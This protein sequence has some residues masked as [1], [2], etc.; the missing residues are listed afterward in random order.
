MSTV[1]IKS[2]PINGNLLFPIRL[3]NLNELK[4]ENQQFILSSMGHGIP[5]LNSAAFQ[6]EIISTSFAEDKGYSGR[7]IL[8][9]MSKSMAVIDVTGFHSL[10]NTIAYTM[11]YS[12]LTSFNE[13][14]LDDFRSMA[15]PQSEANCFAAIVHELCHQLGFVHA[16]FWDKH[17]TVPY[18]FQY[19]VVRNFIEFYHIQSGVLSHTEALYKF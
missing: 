7:Q 2:D 13:K 14:Y 17:R 9:I 4:D 12:H 6:N 11:V 16:H 1:I 10:S 15:F 3:G 8:E 5:V 18:M 19:A